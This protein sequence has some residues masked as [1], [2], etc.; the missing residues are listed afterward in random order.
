MTLKPRAPEL[1]CD[2]D[3]PAVADAVV[4]EDAEADVAVL[5][6][7]P[8]TLEPVMLT[9]PVVEPGLVA[10]D[11]AAELVGVVEVEEPSPVWVTPEGRLTVED[12]PAEV[13]CGGRVFEEVAIAVMPLELAALM[14]NAGEML[15][16]VPNTVKREVEIWVCSGA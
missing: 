3:A 13:S 5:P 9:L 15:P 10:V 11:V 4:G 7:E 1:P 12:V 8:D 2:V 6:C 14:V 16:D